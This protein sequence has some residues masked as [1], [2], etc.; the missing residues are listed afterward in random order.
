MNIPILLITAIAPFLGPIGF[1]LT[2]LGM[3]AQASNMSRNE[4][5]EKPSLS[6]LISEALLLL[7]KPRTYVDERLGSR[8]VLKEVVLGSS[9]VYFAEARRLTEVMQLTYSTTG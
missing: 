4:G 3:I 5:V 1:E 6:L 7:G 2:R 8:F 9:A